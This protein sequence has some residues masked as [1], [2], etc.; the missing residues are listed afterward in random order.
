M[1]FDLINHDI[2]NPLISGCF[3]TKNLIKQFKNAD[4]I[5]YSDLIKL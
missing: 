5:I 2:K 4:S 3:L 1:I